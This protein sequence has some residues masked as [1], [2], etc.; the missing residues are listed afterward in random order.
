MTDT[1][2]TAAQ[3]VRVSFSINGG[4]VSLELDPRVTLASALR[5][6]LVVKGGKQARVG[7]I[8]PQI[9]Q[10][11]RIVGAPAGADEDGCFHCTRSFAA[12]TICAEEGMVAA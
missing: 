8:P 9:A 11:G 2:G 12:A 6:T 5:G 3:S 4:V 10:F 1:D 7:K